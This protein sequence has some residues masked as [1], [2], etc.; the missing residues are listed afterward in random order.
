[1]AYFSINI[2]NFEILKHSE[3]PLEVYIHLLKFNFSSVCPFNFDQKQVLQ[4]EEV[5]GGEE[6]N[7]L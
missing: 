6:I 3:Y 1:M 2:M 7:N 5:A 4:G